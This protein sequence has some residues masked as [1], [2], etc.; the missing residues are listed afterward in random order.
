MTPA[1][2][3][4][5][6]FSKCF[7]GTLNQSNIEI[8]A[9]TRL[10]KMARMVTLTYVI[11][12]FPS[13]RMRRAVVVF[14]SSVRSQASERKKIEEYMKESSTVCVYL[15]PHEENS[16]KIIQNDFFF[17]SKIPVVVVVVG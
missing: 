6:M 11:F 5:L 2:H 12:L 16:L 1:G 15:V 17:N 10:G 4:F 3:R 14:G 13:D 9:R 8:L 7:R